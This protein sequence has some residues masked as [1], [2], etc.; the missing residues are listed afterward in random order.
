M[1][2]LLRRNRAEAPQPSPDPRAALRQGQA[3]AQAARQAAQ[4]AAEAAERARQGVD[5]ARARLAAYARVDEAAA[6]HRADAIRAGQVS[7]GLPPDLAEL[8]REQQAAREE[9]ADAEAAHGVLA[10]EARDAQEAADQ[11]EAELRSAA[12]QVMQA[13]ALALVGRMRRRERDAAADRVLAVGLLSVRTPSDAPL[14]WGLHSIAME[15][16]HGHMIDVARDARIPNGGPVW[17][18][19]RK[20]LLE[21][22][23]ARFPALE[24]GDG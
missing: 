3:R 12:D 23:A 21:D 2:D 1:L 13:A 14:D 6:R 19:F 18:A 8:R 15:P 24:G 16:V 5:A 4:Q 20:A 10:A 9:L 22:P 17:V 11:A 7:A